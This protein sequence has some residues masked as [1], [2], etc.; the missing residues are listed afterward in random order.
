MEKKGILF[1]MIVILAFFVTGEA[2]AQRGGGWRGNGGWGP[3]SNY[4]RIY[5]PSSVE[6]LAGKVATVER[7]SPAKGRS[8]YGIHLMVVTDGEEISV[9]LGP[10]WHIESQDVS[11]E[12]GDAIE[13]T[14]SRI[15]Y[16]GSPAIV[17]AEI[18][19]G[20]ETLTLRDAAGYPVWSRGGRGGNRNRY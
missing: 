13:V 17:A 16:N 8:S 9:H 11:F 19:K 18:R 6:T 14:G 7:F 1:A 5:D 15:I 3:G 20:G 4:S 2:F 10:G 12:V